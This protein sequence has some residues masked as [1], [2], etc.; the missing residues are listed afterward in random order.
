M[1]W[2]KFDEITKEHMKEKHEVFSH[3]TAVHT[4]ALG[5]R[6]HITYLQ[7]STDSCHTVKKVLSQYLI[8]IKAQ[9]HLKKE[10]KK[11]LKSRGRTDRKG[12]AD[13]EMS[14]LQQKEN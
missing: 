10:K 12:V 5:V 2:A 3:D 11:G 8:N 9:G 13:G 6:K 1:A 4:D 7:T 14:S